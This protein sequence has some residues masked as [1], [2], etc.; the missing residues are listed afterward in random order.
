MSTVLDDA[1]LNVYVNLDRTL[2]ASLKLKVGQNLLFV[3]ALSN[4]SGPI[5]RKLT[6]PKPYFVTADLS[7]GLHVPGQPQGT[8]I[9]ALGLVHTAGKAAIQIEFAPEDICAALPKSLSLSV[10]I[11]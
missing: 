8:Y 5:L 2:P 11:S 1:S 3:R 9:L 6:M 4:A 10:E 7:Y